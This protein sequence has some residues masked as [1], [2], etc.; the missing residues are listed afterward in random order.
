MKKLFKKH[1]GELVK[2]WLRKYVNESINKPE[3]G[4][5]LIFPQQMETYF[6]YKKIIVNLINNEMGENTW[7]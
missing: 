3:T 7:T 1:Q 6:F 2:T 5:Q 4:F